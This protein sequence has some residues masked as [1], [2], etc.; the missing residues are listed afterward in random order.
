MEPGDYVRLSI[1]DD[2]SGMSEDA[3][4]RAFEPFFTTKQDSN[5]T[6]LGLAMVYGFVRQSGGHI[7]LYSE[8]DH[9]TSFGLYFPAL[10]SGQ[11]D[12]AIQA[13]ET[14][15]AK[16]QRIGNGETVLVVEDNS[17]VRALSIA[18]L[19]DLGFR[20]QEAESGDVAYQ[21]LQDGVH[22]DILFSDLVMPGDLNGYDLA[23][24]ASVDFPRL[25]V[26]LT[27]GYASDVVTQAIARGQAY[28]I[29]H[30][31]YRQSDLAKRLQSLLA[32]ESDA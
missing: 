10:M 14:Q 15:T 9:G 6:G 2:G 5:G 21:M 26:L 30:K 22:V 13:N 32:S 3:Q 28:D 11:T 17:K 25:K 4:K 20:T 1:S 8:V 31:P 12:T 27:S 29:L 16:G 23:A 7:T 18:R 19:Q 24:K